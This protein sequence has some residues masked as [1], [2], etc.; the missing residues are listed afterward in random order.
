NAKGLRVLRVDETCTDRGLREL[1]NCK[2]LEHLL[3]WSSAVTDDGLKYAK[4]MPKLKRLDLSG[5]KKVNGAG[6][7]DLPTSIDV[8][9]LAFLP[10]TDE[11][12]AHLQAATNLQV[13]DLNA[14]KITD[15]GLAHLEK[16]EN[17]RELNLRHCEAIS[18]DAIKHIVKIKSLQKLCL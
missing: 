7:K 3:L 14:T 17:L 16:L 12:L 4:D 9:G 11:S 8:L 5:S 18:D 1:T 6:L 13:L 2:E 10:I 15:D